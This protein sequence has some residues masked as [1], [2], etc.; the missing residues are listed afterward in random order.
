MTQ[1]PSADR[2]EL[3]ISDAR[4]YSGPDVTVFDVE[5][6]PWI[7]PQNASAEQVAEVV[8]RC[9]SGALHYRLQGPREDP[10]RPTRAAV[11]GTPKGF[12]PRYR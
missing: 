9:A 6:R 11:C 7:Q 4:A 5:K 1:K 8:G 3:A 10:E 2:E 12:L